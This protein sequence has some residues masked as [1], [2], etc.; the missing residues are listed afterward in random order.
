MALTKEG[1][2]VKRLAELKKEYD[3]L[4]I[5]RFGPINTQPDS[6]IGQLEGIW[7]EAL[8]NLYEQAQDTYHAMYPF[9]AEGVSLDGAVSYVGI[10]RFTATATWTIAAVYGRESTLLKSGAQASDGVQRYQSVLDAVISRANAVDTLIDVNVQ[11]GMN[12]V[13]NVNGM[14]I[15]Y[16]SG[17]NATLEEIAFGLGQQFNPDA[18]RYELDDGRLRIFA[19]DGVTPFALSVGERMKMVRIG[20]PARFVSMNE[21]RRVLPQGALREIVTPRSGWEDVCNLVEGV[22]GR[23]RESDT[24]LRTRFEQSR[25]S[26]GSAT[27]KAIRARLIQD[28]SG[29]SEVRIFENRTNQTS[30]DGIP[31]HAFEALVVG[32]SDQSVADALWTH[33][34]AGIETYGANSIMVKD[35]N[36]DGQ[37]ICFSRATQKYAW[38]RVHVTGLYDEEALPQDI[39][40]TI[41]RAVMSYG[42]SL[43]I[44]ED[45]ILQRMLGPIYA[46]TTGLA[47]IVIEAAVTESPEALP[48]YGEGNIAIDKRST[49][50]FDEARLEVIGL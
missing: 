40:S 49:A 8:A 15:S 2:A 34:P 1:Y 12:Y 16:L 13:L 38:I 5:N 46:N 9:S 3:R 36:G 21:G 47:G 23:E 20:S 32:G 28:V 7:A 48:A 43:S 31:P 24:E 33:K 22:T 37:R 39:I 27:V 14:L 18:M 45:I 30:D 41:K 10:T 19:T 11:S 44:G 42:E 4:L 50:V 25:Q 26:L 29:V 6:V 17:S 35:E